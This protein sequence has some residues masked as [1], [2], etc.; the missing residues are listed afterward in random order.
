M[1]NRGGL[2]T[3]LPSTSSVNERFI[4]LNHLSTSHG[5]FLQVLSSQFW[6]VGMATIQSQY[7]RR[8]DTLPPSPHHGAYLDTKG[9][10][11]DSYQVETVS[12]DVSM[13]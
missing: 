8:I 12:I 2:L 13:I 5:L 3:Y 6:T 10:P 9:R 11:K 1:G 4:P 7:V